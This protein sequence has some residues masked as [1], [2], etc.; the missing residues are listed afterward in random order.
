MTSDLRIQGEVVVN[1]EQAE[2][3][4]NRVGDKAQQMAT[5][6]AT[7]A[8]KAGQAVDK[9]GDGAGASAEKF[10][11]A[12]SRMSA[13][14][15][16]AT[17]ELELLGKTASQRLEFNIA[18]KGLDAAKFEPALQKLREVEAQAAAAQRAASGSLD[19]MG[20]SAAQTA[21]ALRGVPAQFTDIITSLQGGQAPLTV[22]LQQGGQLK[23]MF[24]GAGNAAKALGGFVMGLITPFTLA[25]GTVAAVA[26]AYREGSKEADAYNKAIITTG[27]AAGTTASQMQQMAQRIGSVVGTQGAAADAL[28]KMAGSSRIAADNFEYFG[29]VALKVE[30]TVGT[31]VAETVKQFAEL[32]KSP[33]DASK[34]LNEETNYLTQSIYEQIKALKDQGR[35]AD[36]AS[37]AQ[38]AWADALNNRSAEMTQNLGLIEKAWKGVAGAAKSGWDAMLNVGRSSSMADEIANVRQQ[39]AQAQ[40]QDK[41]RQFS[42]PWDT[43][44]A[45]L[46]QRLSYLTEEERLMKRGAA[47]Q[48]E[49]AQAEKAAIEATDALGKVNEKAFTKQEQM[50]KALDDYRANLEKVRAVNP[51]SALLDPAQVAKS[52]KAIR[53]QFAE[54]TKAVTAGNSELEKQAALIAKLSGLDPKFSSEWEMLSKAYKSGA[55][56][57]DQLVASQAALLAK[58]P[59]ITAEMKAQ[60]EATKA[61]NKANESAAAARDKYIVSLGT[62]LDKIQ[63]DIAAQIEATERMGLSKE[64]IAE[65]DA[66]K[67]EMLATDLELQAIKALDRNLDEQ[68]YAALKKQ[69]AAY[70]ELGIA[71][72]GGA[73][74]E[75]ALEME[76]ANADAAKKAQE[77]WER[78]S[79][80]IN[81]TLTDAL[82]RGFESGK[83]FAKNL[84]DTV[85]NMFKTMV[86]RPVISAVLSP[87][88]MALSGLTGAGSAAAGQAGGSALGSAGGSLMGSALGG[89][90]AF[91]TGAS[92][93]AASLFANG[94]TGTLAAGGQMIG[95]GSVMSGLG[96]IAGALGPIAIGIALLSSLIKKSTPH[97]GGIGAYSAASGATTGSSVGLAFGIDQKHYTQAGEDLSTNVAKSIVGILDS[98]AT[99]FGKQ[100]GYYAATA[101]A[102]DSSKDGAWG[103]LRIKFGEKVLLDWADTAV[104]DANVP[105]E[106]ADGEAGQKEYLAEVAKGARDALVG[107]IGDVDWATDML[108]ALGESPTLESLAQTVQQINAAQAAFES[109]GKNIVGFGALTDGAIS[110]L[111]KAAGSIDGLVSA[112]SAYYENFYREEEKTANVMRDVAEALAKVNLPLPK[113]RDEFRAMVDSQLKL[114]ES[115]A[116]AVAALLGVSGAFASVTAASETAAEAAARLAKEQEAAQQAA[117]Q[118]AEAAA[119]RA[120]EIAQERYG[121]ETQIMQLLGDTAG[122]RKREIEALDASNRAL[123]EH[124]YA[125]EDA[126]AAYEKSITAANDAYSVLE[127]SVGRERGELQKALDAER[128]A[129]SARYKLQQDGHA[130]QISAA[131]VAADKLRGIASALSGALRNMKVESPALDRA[132]L[133]SARGVI[134]AAAASLDVM[135]PGLEAAL[136]V[137]T[138]DVRKMYGRWEDF[139]FDQG[140]TAGQTAA[141]SSAA[142]SQLSGYESI[143]NALKAQDDVAKLL[144]DAEMAAAQERFDI[145]SKKLDAQLEQ[146]KSMLDRLLGIEEGTLSSVEALARL[147]DAVNASNAALQAQRAAEAAARMAVMQ[148]GG[149]GG[150]GVATQGAVVGNKYTDADLMAMGFDPADLLAYTQLSQQSGV[151]GGLDRVVDHILRQGDEALWAAYGMQ[152]LPTSKGPNGEVYTTLTDKTGKTYDSMKAWADSFTNAQR[153]AASEAWTN[154]SAGNGINP[155]ELQTILQIGSAADRQLYW[156]GGSL[157]MGGFSGKDGQHYSSAGIVN[158]INT[159]L[160]Q[161]ASV[162]DVLHAGQANFGLDEEDIR[163]AARAAGIPGFATGINRVPHDMLARIHKDEAVV[164]AAYNPYNPSASVPGNSEVVAELRKLNERIARIEASSNATAGHTAGTDR[165][166]ARVIQNDALKTETTV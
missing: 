69:A 163:T 140:V 80:Q 17:N 1:S 51:N 89:I 24:G 37:V 124:I 111:V 11:R 85:V 73:A 97:T 13:S 48:A 93:G 76:K 128:E 58:Q 121:L 40:G 108:T 20:I 49:R 21:A 98:T 156:A 100:A 142:Q 84:R 75:A 106:F 18:D 135:A 22:F 15:K 61:I 114:G 101:F 159:V 161:G 107:A 137:V 118:A 151:Q 30:K 149:G 53:D 96:T 64:A 31:S 33:V 123:Q 59:A 133:Q 122:L 166:L 113:T 120:A 9:I 94:L 72:K 104:R 158:A 110:Q 131:Q 28:A 147:T 4:F 2:T 27:N 10:T 62:G 38:K 141:L 8:G 26:F 63:A 29:E 57:L 42:L 25:A 6:V 143:V 47:A 36:A 115:G 52:E 74:K 132:R 70:R 23:D 82:L 65:L 81:N 117:Q 112:A 68:T 14:I 83:D 153:V 46:Q 95:A 160:A 60:E 88:S 145:E 127:S 138:G 155:H 78:A 90:G 67:L 144:A 134:G 99:T 55:L 43:P 162:S 7:S 34:K 130:A 126:R 66:A 136:S 16:R 105:R 119:R 102:D 157:D 139:A 148:G 86:L 146:G 39:I 150:G 91:G 165:K 5:E 41:N 116:T 45:D 54:R 109:L 129:I 92:Y 154:S 87:V 32:G 77:D 50:N 35:E 125:I 44:L 12:E 152:H 71:K 164:P 56:S 79:E 19:K 3:A 103:A